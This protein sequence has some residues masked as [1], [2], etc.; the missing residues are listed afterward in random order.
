MSHPFEGGFF[1]ATM[2]ELVDKADS[3]SVAKM[4]SGFESRLWH[5]SVCGNSLPLLFLIGSPSPFT[6]TL[7]ARF[8]FVNSSASIK[9][10]MFRL[11]ETLRGGGVVSLYWGSL[12]N[13]FYG[14]F[15]LWYKGSE[16]SRGGGGIP[17]PPPPFMRSN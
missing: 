9:L 2:L 1:Y 16:R 14:D 11:V 3:K 10:T 4:A 12:K 15:P 17:I 7:A 8:A 13:R 5:Q 6:A